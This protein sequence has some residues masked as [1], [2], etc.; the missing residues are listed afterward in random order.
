MKQR[1]LLCLLL[2]FALIYFAVPRIPLGDPGLGGIFAIAWLL[3]ALIV[4]G[5]NLVGLLYGKE[6][7]KAPVLT[8]DT[9]KEGNK[10]RRYSR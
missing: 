8:E 3:F 1:L 4:V 2:A 5:G 6:R 7:R 9:R 10:L